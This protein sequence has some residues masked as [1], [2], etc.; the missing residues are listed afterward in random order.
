MKTVKCIVDVKQL[1]SHPLHATVKALCRCWPLLAAQPLKPM[2]MSFCQ[3]LAD[4]LPVSA[5]REWIFRTMPATVAKPAG[6]DNARL[7][8]SSTLGATPV[9]QAEPGKCDGIGTTRVPV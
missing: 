2:P 7:R 9:V 5:W 3:P 4:M 8:C 1:R 6:R